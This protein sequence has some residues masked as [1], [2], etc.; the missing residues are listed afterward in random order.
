M[1]LVLTPTAHWQLRLMGDMD[2]STTGFLLGSMLGRVIMIDTLFPLEFNKKNIS[3][4]YHRVFRET[5]DRLKGVFFVNKEIFLNDWFLE[6][7]IFT[8]S[9]HENRIFFYHFD[10]DE[11]QRRC[12]PVAKSEEW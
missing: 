1:K 10:S 12:Q 11:G 3:R 6:N 5:G 4:V 8:I 2:F 7:Y 9:G